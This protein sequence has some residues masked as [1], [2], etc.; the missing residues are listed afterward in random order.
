GHG[1]VFLL[2]EWHAAQSIWYYYPVALS[3]K[4]PTALLLGTAI[5]LLLR[6]RALA[7]WAAAAVALLLLVS[8]TCRV[9][10]GIRYFLPLLALASVAVATGLARAIAS[11]HSI[12]WRRTALA[13]GTAVCA[14]AAVCAA[15]IWPDGLRYTNALW[16]GADR[17]Y[18]L[19]CDSNYDWGQGLNALAAWQR[20]QHVAMMDVVYFGT[21][22]A[23]S[24]QDLRVR[25]L[26]EISFGEPAG[27]RYVAVSPTVLYGLPESQYPVARRLRSIAPAA[28]A[29]PFLIFDL[30]ANELHAAKSR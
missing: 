22:P 10:I 13:A 17:G 24:R 21:D 30:K 11:L 9:Q 1:G 12:P 3:I 20:D 27:S 16:G 23:V 15:S 26:G 25:S 28:R 29:G 8:L 19:L 18:T 4:A 5:V 7:S 2:G 14:W 6:P